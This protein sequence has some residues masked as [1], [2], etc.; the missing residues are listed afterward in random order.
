MKKLLLPLILLFC[1]NLL[2]QIT[3]THNVG[4]TPIKTDWESCDYE[5]SWARTFTLSD[6]GVT[7]SDQLIIKSGQTAISNSYNGA[8]ISF[9]V[10]SIDDNF[11]NS[12]KVYLG[13]GSITA[14][15]IGNN[16]KIIDITFSRPV[17]IPSKTTKI[18]VT[19]TQSEDIYNPDYKKVLIAG[20][21]Q[22]NDFSWFYGCREHYTYIT[23]DKL[24]SPKPNAN[25]FINVTGEKR[26]LINTKSNLTLSSN[27]TDEV[28]ETGIYGCSWG[29]VSWSKSFTLSDFGITE[30]EEYIIKSGQI[31]LVES[32][33]WDTNVEFNIY[34]IDDNFPNS[35]SETNLIGKSKS[36]SQFASPQNAHISIIYFDNPIVVD[37]NVKKILVEVKQLSSLSSSAVAF[38]AGTKQDNGISWFKSYNGGCPPFNEFKNTADLG[39]ANTNF[40]V[41]VNGEAKTILPFEITNNNNCINFSNDLS[42]TNQSEIKSVVWHFD[43][44]S[45]GTNNT[46][47]SIDVDHQFTSAGIYNVTAEVVHIDN[48]SYTIPK[49]IEI[50]DTP[51]IN[52]SVALKQC[53]NSDINGFSFFNLNEVKEEII[54]NPE[55]YTITFHEEK[56]DAE[57]SSSEIT[58]TTNYQNET[59][60]IDKIWARIENENGCYEVSEVNLYVSTTQIPAALLKSYYQCDDGTN[61]TDG[62]AT[63]NFSDV[64]NDIIN[65]FPVN[66]QLI[67]NY[68]RNEEDALAE[69]NMISDIT[70][71]QNIGY[72]NQ[73]NIYIRVDSKVD[74]DCLGL[75]AHISL[76]VEKVPIANPVTVNPECDNDKDGFFAFD[77]STIHNTIIGNQTD[78]TVTYFDENG[79]QL[80]SPLQNPFKTKTQNVIARIENSNSIDLDGKCYD[81]TTI[82]FTVNTV[83]T[84][85]IVSIQEECDDDFDG[86]VAFDTSNIES[87]VIGTQTNLIVKY[88]DENNNLLPSPL[89]NPFNTASQTIRVRLENPIYDIC[90]EET[91][92]DFVVREKPTVNLITEDIICITNNSQLEIKVDNPNSDYSY[93]WRDENNNIVSNSFSTTVF[94]GGI[95]NVIATSKYGCDSDKEEIIIKESSVSTITIN[96]I[97][98]QDDSENNFIKINTSNL[99]LGDY[100]FRLLDDN[101]NVI[102]DYQNNPS[103]ENLEGGN[104]TLEINDLNNCG[105][106]PFEIS[107]ISFPDY[108]T[109]NSDGNNDYWQ[110]KGIKKSYYKEG[111]INIFNRYGKQIASFSINDL[112]WDGTYNGN[113]LGSNNYWF[114]AIL[115]NQQNQIKS[116]TGNFSLIRK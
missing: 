109:P 79:V 94:K 66:Q 31:G 19:V 60:S 48:T 96:D 45:S 43:D 91:T 74:N 17:V 10:F 13:G 9:A 30:N 71:Y 86:I 77:T 82:N 50:F 62:I 47:T 72:P 2:S 35:F 15:E 111:T 51:N 113:L 76:N 99:G 26:S 28:F 56:I 70:N 6:F 105:S 18:L 29:G 39:K 12:N 14:P 73:Q 108:F 53:D 46:A 44:P 1:L 85:N 107:L 37:A 93:T 75:G 88:F 16:P 114:K 83:P 41:T 89:T 69:E 103:F 80:S 8:R 33:E 78:V 106:V 5:E 92:I 98:V 34:E 97:E 87:S 52:P 112:G 84:A 4:N 21:A 95:Y 38:A 11:P 68:Y 25:F 22:D 58:N 64:T 67:I 110:I 65:I 61:L 20:T 36:K 54:T 57:N 23:T 42:L 104:Y 81:E 3:L 59:V 63:F 40:F 49:E 116:R 55:N 102:F 7:T 27:I 24:N 101:S 32:N 100:E 90:F 115:V